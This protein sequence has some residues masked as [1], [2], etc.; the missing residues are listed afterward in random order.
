[1]TES[2]DSFTVEIYQL[3]NIVRDSAY[4]GAID[5]NGCECTLEDKLRDI[6]HKE[7]YYELN[8]PIKVVVTEND[9][10]V[11]LS[12]FKEHPFDQSY[13]VWN[14]TGLYKFIYKKVMPDG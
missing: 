8:E 7:Y 4:E 10:V 13:S 6:A 12:K 11:F 1:M 3:G 2:I 5:E 14:C 9:D